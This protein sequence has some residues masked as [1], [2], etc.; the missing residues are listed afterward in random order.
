MAAHMCFLTCIYLL[1]C[2]LFTDKQHSSPRRGPNFG[3]ARSP[4]EGA[5]LPVLCLQM[6]Q[7][8]PGP[9]KLY[10]PIRSVAKLTH[11]KYP[12]TWASPAPMP[13][14]KAVISSVNILNPVVTNIKSSTFA[15]IHARIYPAQLLSTH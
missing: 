4:P 2:S 5:V 6:S 9:E 3:K 8:R 15:N 7:G 14:S 12:G 1:T 13:A 11:L 10:F